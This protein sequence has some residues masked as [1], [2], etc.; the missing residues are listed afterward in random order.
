MARS[1]ISNRAIQERAAAKNAVAEA[2][3][4]FR[5]KGAYAIDDVSDRLT[6]QDRAADKRRHDRLVL[7]ELERL[8]R[9]AR[10]G[11]PKY[12]VTV[13]KPPVFSKA[14]FKRLLTGK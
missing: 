1:K 9:E 2:E 6:D 14:W 11:V 3:E 10:K 13:W 4:L 7:L 5:T 8:D 12:W